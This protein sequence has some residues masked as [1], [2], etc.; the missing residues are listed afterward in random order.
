MP[1]TC[2]Q[3]IFFWCSCL[4]LVETLEYENENFANCSIELKWRINEADRLNG[5]NFC[6]NIQ[7]HSFVACVLTLFF[8][9]WQ[10]T[11]ESTSFIC[12]YLPV[13]LWPS[14]WRHSSLMVLS[15]EPLQSK[16][17][18]IQHQT[19]VLLITQTN[20]LFTIPQDSHSRSS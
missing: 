7:W 16:N 12:R 19:T 5:R 4:Y 11:Q 14:S 8:W 9:N 15:V 18:Y 10:Q 2:K 17:H 1:V 20:R 6:V 3:W 13:S